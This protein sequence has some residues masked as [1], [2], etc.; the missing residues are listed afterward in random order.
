MTLDTNAIAKVH[1]ALFPGY[2]PTPARP[3]PALASE[4]GCAAVYVKDESER[5]GLPAFKV[6]GASWAICSVLGQRW[7]VDPWDVD[8]LRARAQQEP[9]LTAFAA[10]DGKSR[11]GLP[12]RADCRQPRA[13]RRTH[14]PPARVPRAHLR[15]LHGGAVVDRR[16]RV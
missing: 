4:L 14:R 7:G 9:G 15:P 5:Y 3:V 16:D 13:R 12:A 6:L 11:R 10:T 8:A 1:T 2:G